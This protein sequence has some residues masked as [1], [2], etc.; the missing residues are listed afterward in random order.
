MPQPDVPTN[1]PFLGQLGSGGVAF[2]KYVHDGAGDTT[3]YTAV[4]QADKGPP[5]SPA[6]TLL[7]ALAEAQGPD[8]GYLWT[9]MEGTRD[10]TFPPAEVPRGFC[11]GEV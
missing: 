6:D 9:G 1:A 5:A 3:I 11:C 7:G 4:V 8:D 10:P 2:T